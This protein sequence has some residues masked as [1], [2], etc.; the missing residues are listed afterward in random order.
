MAKLISSDG[1][2]VI[3]SPTKKKFTLKQIYKLIKCDYVQIV[4]TRQGIMFVDEDG[5][6]SNSGCEYNEV[7]T[8]IAFPNGEDT[9]V[10]N[11]FLCS[12]EELSKGFF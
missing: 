3:V 2:V 10:G 1:L 12:K 9:I 11:A 7:A 5:K 6:L 4:N 8:K